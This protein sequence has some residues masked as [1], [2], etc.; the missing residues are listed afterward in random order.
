MNNP[1]QTSTQFMLEEYRDLYE[2]IMHLE[3]KLFNHLS[4]FTT[5]FLGIM[6]ASVA[7][8]QLTLARSMSLIDAV[9]LVTLPFGLLFAV[10]RFEI[11]MTTELRIRKM[12]FVEG[13][14]RIREYFVTLDGGISNYLVLPYR[15]ENAP[16]YLRIGSQDWYQILYLCL[17]N[18]ISFVLFWSGL[19]F[20]LIFLVNNLLNQNRFIPPGIIILWTVVG[21]MLSIIIFWKLSYLNV[22]DFCDVYN[23]D[24]EVRMGKPIDYKLLD[25]PLPKSKL[26]WTFSDWI[27]FFDRKHK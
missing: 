14:S 17:M 13:I 8:V 2:N 3:N 11:R 19:P 26:E 18:S 27:R 1:E 21:V 12:K 24:R 23:N 6:T 22:M 4:F 9:G 15:I 20:L 5:L 16:P 7:V 10:G 25:R